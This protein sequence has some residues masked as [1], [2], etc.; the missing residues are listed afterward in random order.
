MRVPL[1]IGHRLGRAYGPDSSRRALAR[2]LAGGVG[3]LETDLCLTADGELV[4]LH[5]P[6]LAL[7]TSLSGWAHERSAREI[8]GTQLLDRHGEVSDEG[9]LGLAELLDLVPDDVLLQLEV[10]AHADPVLAATTAARICELCRAERDRLEL[11]SFHSSACT[12]AASRG[13]RSRLVVWTDHEPERLAA[14]ARDHR[15]AG[16]SIEHFLLSGAMARALRSA[17]LSVNTG[18]INEIELAMR[19]IELAAPDAICSDRP[20]EL[21]AELDDRIE[22]GADVAAERPVVAGPADGRF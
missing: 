6:L 22:L 4:V 12:T 20:V 11:I 21:R 7:G 9:P 16:V 2:S 8:L 19:A 17:G 18:T 3:A 1:L 15:V 13:F 10:K 5:D 14:W